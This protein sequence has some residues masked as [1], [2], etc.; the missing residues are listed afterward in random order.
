MS[1]EEGS[2]A[3]APELAAE[4]LRLAVADPTAA[5]RLVVEAEATARTEGDWRSVSRA[6]RAAGVA[7][8]Q[9]RRLDR[10]EERLR[11]AVAAARRAE[12]HELSGEAR[13]SLASAL[14]LRG[15]P[16]EAFE[17][18]DGA[19]GELA[20]AGVSARV[21]AARARARRAALLQELGRIEE[22]LAELRLALPL[23]RRAGDAQWEVQALSNR[24]LMLN[25][26]RQFGAA[27]ADL[28]RAQRLC[29][30]H[31]F[32][33]P[34]AYLEQNLGCVLADRGEI[35]AALRHFDTAAE[36]YR[37]LGIRVGSLL[38]DRATV[39]LS[40]RLV[41]E[42]RSSAE[43]AVEIFLAQGRELNVPEARLLVSTAALLQHDLDAS[44]A[45]ARAAVTEF[46]RLR[47]AEWLAL[48]DCALLQ[49]EYRVLIRDHAAS[50]DA[51]TGRRL[52][53]RLRASATAS[54]QFGWVVSA[55]EVRLLAARLA[56]DLGEPEVARVELAAT[57]HLRRSGPA[58]VRAR[59]W[60]G[61]ALL[62]R[63]LGAR[64]GARAA[65]RAG[66]RVL[67]EFSTTLG[68]ASCGRRC[69]STGARWPE[70]VCRWRSRTPTPAQST[71]GANKVEPGP[72]SC[73]ASGRRRI[74][75]CCAICRTCGPRWPRSTSHVVTVGQRRT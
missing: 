22:A 72:W 17:N 34:S 35:P 1:I 58:D 8:L 52:L 5:L 25:G 66:L 27:E 33:L 6:C 68:R 54:E 36:R 2:T 73:G 30:E 39:L 67:E 46:P 7:E 23:L 10:A 3:R 16:D 50:P 29:A 69:R 64:Q 49:A 40:V 53:D 57:A 71:G 41:A 70:R 55:Q 65:L 15:R 31:G 75:N 51:D 61:E 13:M 19:I 60:L 21:A 48:A 24:S 59:A 56:L 45:A 47:R 43:E 44:V 26:R 14:M 74:Q 12:D 37:S 9:L 4:A 32:T 28:V 11:A 63:D 62:R 20:E 18:I 38:V 42:A